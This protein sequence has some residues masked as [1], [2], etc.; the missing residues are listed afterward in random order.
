MVSCKGR[1]SDVRRGGPRFGCNCCDLLGVRVNDHFVDRAA[2][3]HVADGDG[4]YWPLAR[5]I[6]Y[7]LVRDA[8]AATPRNY[9]P[10]YPRISLHLAMLRYDGRIEEQ[11][12]RK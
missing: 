1:I 7:V 6:S 9:E 11:T 2:C 12:W 10:D 4:N 3:H 8:F 5:K